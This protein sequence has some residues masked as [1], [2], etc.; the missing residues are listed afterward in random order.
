MS[1]LDLKAG[2]WQV[3]VAEEDRHKTA[4]TTPFRTFRFH[5]MHFGLKNSPTTFQRLMDHFRTGLS[6]VCVVAYLDDLLVVSDDVASHVRDLRKVFDRLRMFDL[7]ANRDKCIFARNR[8]RYLSHVISSQGIQTDPEKV[9]AIVN[10]RSPSNL[11][12]YVASFKLVVGSGNSFRN[13]TK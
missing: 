10:M 9:A 12:S 4:F 6:D 3:E 7:K 11:K 2:Y 8:G 1:T 5:R 13:F